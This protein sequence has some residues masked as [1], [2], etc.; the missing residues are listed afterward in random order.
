MI[1]NGQEYKSLTLTDKRGN[2]IFSVSD[3]DIFAR[4]EGIVYLETKEGQVKYRTN[5]KKVKAVTKE[6]TPCLE[7]K[8]VG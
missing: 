8:T 6:G 5:G 2:V 1:I 4:T 7:L 3:D